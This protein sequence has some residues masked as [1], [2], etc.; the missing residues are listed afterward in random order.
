MSSEIY[1]PY[2]G[3]NNIISYTKRKEERRK[4][5][6]IAIGGG[7][8]GVGKTFFT[9]NLCIYLSRFGKVNVVDLDL[10]G[11]NLHTSFGS[12][13]PNR[14]LSDLLSGRVT[15][16]NDIVTTT[17]NPNLSIISGSTDSYNIAD[18]DSNE[19]RR[20]ISCLSELECDYL[21]LDLGAGTNRST[22]NF[23]LS[24]EH[25]IV[26]ATPE[27]TS[28]ENCYRFLKS[29]FYQ[30]L[31]NIEQEL[32]LSHIVGQCMD[33]KNNLG[34]KS[35]SDLLNSL[36]KLHP[37]VGDRFLQ[38]VQRL[39]F[40]V[41]LNQVRTLHDQ[42]IGI[43]MESVCTRY[44]GVNTKFLGAINH[45]D[46]VWQSLRKKTPLMIQQPNNRLNY[47]IADIAK[48]LVVPQKQ[49]QVL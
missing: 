26:V 5:V 11:A 33:Q 22:L 35:P 14:S 9:T 10:G 49:K 46:A 1:Y 29:A 27:P 8:G 25:Q 39:Q 36:Q 31:R 40:E 4:P 44:F 42:Q 20:L 45:D 32:G 13:I 2:G 47:Q 38:E 17:N 15:N 12:A 21:I 24:A 28:I 41:V 7:K 16:I 43:G 37:E 34:I 30:N 3:V 19:E 18:I 48:Q 23:F 6:L